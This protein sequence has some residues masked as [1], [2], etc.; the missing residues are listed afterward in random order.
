MK[1][2]TTL[3]GDGWYAIVRRPP[4]QETLPPLA[5]RLVCWALIDLEDEPLPQLVGMMLCGYGG[6]MV[7]PVFDHE[8]FIGYWDGC[9]SAE[10]AV[11][12][13]LAILVRQQHGRED[14]DD[15][16]APDEEPPPAPRGTGRKIPTAFRNAW[17]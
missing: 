2:L 10:E 9:G 5:M 15:E 3:P 4:P 11:A 8:G 16:E 1:I 14:D 13:A 12:Q 7:V 17:A 6:Q